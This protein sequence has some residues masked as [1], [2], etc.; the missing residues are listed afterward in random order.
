MS[1]QYRDA[2]LH[3]KGKP[4]MSLPSIRRIAPPC[5]MKGGRGLLA[6]LIAVL[7][8]ALAAL[9][10]ALPA[11]ALA[12]G[13]Q[14]AHAEDGTVY[15]DVD[16][17][18]RAAWNEG[19]VVVMDADWHQERP[20]GVP[21]GK[22]ATLKMNGHKIWRDYAETDGGCIFWLYENSTL[23]LDGSGVNG[24]TRFD[25]EV[26]TDFNSR[27]TKTIEAGGVVTG[28][29]S[30]NSAGGIEMKE[31]STLNLTNVAVV[32]NKAYGA[33]GGGVRADGKNCTINM[34]RSQISYNASGEDGWST[35]GNGGG[36]YLSG[37]DSTISMSDSSVDA[38]YGLFGGGIYCN[39]KNARIEMSDA[40]QIKQNYVYRGGGGIWFDNDDFHLIGGRSA[41]IGSN[42]CD[43]MY[44]GGVGTQDCSDGEISSISFVGNKGTGSSAVGG[45]IYVDSSGVTIKGCSFTQ[46]E[47]MHKGGAIFSCGQNL[48]VENCTFTENSTK[49]WGGAVYLDSR[50]AT[51]TGCTFTGNKATSD[52]SR[53]GAVYNAARYNLIQNCTITGNTSNGEGGGVYT[54]YEDNIYLDGVVRIYG[55]TRGSGGADDLFM[56][57]NAGCTIYAYATSNSG[58]YKVAAGSRIGVRTGMTTKRF[59]AEELSD[60]VAGSYFLD[61]F[62]DFHLEYVSSEQKLYQMPNAAT[63]KVTVNGQGSAKYDQGAQATVDGRDYAAEGMAFLF[64]DTSATTGLWNASDAIKDIYNP[65]LT[66]TDPGADVNLA[67]VYAVRLT[68]VDIHLD[69]PEPGEELPS[70]ATLTRSTAAQLQAPVRWYKVTALG[71]EAVSGKA[72]YGTTYVAKVTAAQNAIDLWNYSFD[73]N[74]QTAPLTIGSDTANYTSSVSVSSQT[75]A[76]TVVSSGYTT[77]NAPLASVDAPA[78]VAVLAGDTAESLAAAMPSGVAGAL[79]DGTR[80]TLALDVAGIDWN[81]CVDE[82]GAPVLGE[83][84]LVRDH[85]DS[86]ETHAYTVGLAVSAPEGVEVPEALA[87]VQV[88]VVVSHGTR[89]VTF[90]PADGGASW[91]A[92]VPWGEAVPAP[93][94][95]SWEGRA[96][97]GWYAQG[98]DVTYDFQ[99]AVTSNLTLTARWVL[100]ECQVTFD[101]D[102]GTPEPDA[103]TVEW[104]ACV[105]DPG[106][107]TKDRAT[108][109]GWYA[110][111]AQDAWDFATPVTADVALTAR[112]EAETRVVTFDPDNGEAVTQVRVAYGAIA[113]IPADPVRAGF[114]FAGWYQSDGSAW[115][116]DAPVTADL[117]LVARWTQP[118]PTSFVDV[119]EGS[120][121]EGWVTQAATLGLMTGY[122]D[123]AGTYTGYFGPDASITR[124][125]VA[126]VLWRMAGC[127]EPEEDTWPFLDAADPGQFYYKAVIWCYENWIVTGFQAGDEKG[128]FCPDRAVSRE[129][130]ALMVYRFEAFAD[131]KTSDVPTDAFELC[132]DKGSVSAWARDAVEWCA[133]ADV[134]SGKDTDEGKR[135]DPQQETTR[136]QAAKVFTR[137]WRIAWGQVEPYADGQA[138]DA[139]QVAADTTA[140]A[141]AEATFDEVATFEAAEGTTDGAAAGE[142]A[143]GEPAAAGAEQAAGAAAVVEQPEPAQPEQPVDE[144]AAAPDAAEYSD[145]EEA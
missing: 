8:G 26:L 126:T 65:V 32:G 118:V 115:N 21:S 100:E 75:G 99:T 121:Y 44:G 110:Q 85:A 54:S 48:R 67:A 24:L 63:Y 134:M 52:D 30:N 14:V 97:Q 129:Q 109:L 64:W 78:D 137:A 18:W 62:G 89:T 92:D 116:S 47:S 124:G 141:Q 56:N 23:T 19:K 139:V 5:S 28:G 91:T 49:T 128:C 43:T 37:A 72:E 11:P 45:A 70:T 57:E 84:G 46:N 17:A 59:I 38:N 20:F 4:A 36:V 6:A 112:W 58:Q 86:E 123:G 136:A 87:T 90:D 51:L 7:V 74:A 80:V 130:L 53:G 73:L 34:K 88:R 35:G 113:D 94:E 33:N 40:S 145:V 27:E 101:A 76:L 93:G 50:Y 119:L 81:A 107:P 132:I 68:S 144:W 2:R 22:T 131:A 103:Q 12:D 135:L 3:E 61:L 29:H 25:V 15:T 142:A 106:A 125:Q 104:G 98:A 71:N 42:S 77:P 39:G 79:A 83:D 1:P 55:N 31:G 41:T 102:G 120:W 111:G 69:A 60:Y 66:F 138:V 122:K 127:P 10:L 96:F 108:F 143:A 114:S 16:T 9:A 133:A 13:G 95:P 140:D 82:G 105:A 117:R